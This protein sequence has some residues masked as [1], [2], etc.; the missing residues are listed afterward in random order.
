V[1]VPDMNGMLPLDM[2]VARNY[3]ALASLL[4]EHNA[5]QSDPSIRTGA[6]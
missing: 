5:V 6:A 3:D 4:R 1:N 2:C